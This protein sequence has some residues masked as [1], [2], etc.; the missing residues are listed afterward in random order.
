MGAGA[1]KSIALELTGT[2][3]GLGRMLDDSGNKVDAFVRKTKQS[4]QSLSAGAIAAKGL[5]IG[6]TAIA[7]GL[8]FAISK[9]VQFDKAM[10]NVN[11]LS[12]LN[13][14]QFAAM[15]K[16]VISMSTKLPQSA[17]VLAEGLYDIASSGFQGADGIKVLDAAAR[18]ASA[19]LTTTAV[20]ARAI[21]GV[22]NAYG[23]GAKD[24]AD[25]S[26]VLFSTVNL[27]VISFDELANNLGDVVGSAAAAKVSIAEVGAAIATMTLSGIKGAQATTSLSSLTTKLIQPSVALKDLYK[28]LGYESGAAALKA[29]GL[30]GVMED[31]RIATGGNITTMLKLFPDIE[32]ARGALA[33]MAVDGAN[34]A[35][36]SDQITDKNKRQGATQAVLNEQMKGVS[37]QWQLFTNKIDAAAISVGIKLLPAVTKTMQVTQDAGAAI[38]LVATQIGTQGAA[39]FEAL[40]HSAASIISLLKDLGTIA[41]SIIEPLAKVGGGALIG[42]FNALA[43]VLEKVTGFMADNQTLV[44]ALGAAYAVHAVGGISAM[45]SGMGIVSD[46]MRG[47]FT[48]S[49]YEAANGVLGLGD[50]AKA[51]GKQLL[52]MAPALAVGGAIAVAVTAWSSYSA[53]ADKAKGITKDVQAVM[54]SFSVDQIGA[55]LAK[56]KAF[57]ADYNSRLDDVGKHSGFADLA[58]D[59]GNFSKNWGTLAM[60]DNLAAVQDSADKASARI[61]QLQYNTVELL[62]VMGTPLPDAAKW[63]NDVQGANGAKAQADAMAQ[64][65]HVMDVLGPKLRAAGV[66]LGTAWDV[67]KLT[68]ASGAVSSLRDGSSQAAAAQQGLIDAMGGV[69]KSLGDAGTAAD[70]LKKALD[71]LMGASLG[72]DEATIAWG[73][74][75]AKLSKTLKENKGD[76]DLNSQGGRNNRKAIIDQVGAL[77]DVLV[78]SANAGEGQQA[79]T[80]K[81]TSGRDAL[82]KA[83]T[84]AG[85][86]KSEM[87]KL[88]AQYKLTPELVQ[89][90]IQQSGAQDTAAKLA[91]VKKQADALARSKPKPAVTL[92]DLASGRLAAVQNRLDAI[93]GRHATASVTLTENTYKNMIETTT[94]K[95]IGI[96]VNAN[97]GV[98]SSYANGKMPDQATI[99]PAQGKKGLVQW[100]EE[101]TGGEAYIPLAAS[102]RSRSEK[103]LDAVAG[104]FGK[105]V[106]EAN[107]NGSFRYPPFRYK[108][109]KDQPSRTEQWRTWS[110]ARYQAY[111]DYR[112]R[113]KLSDIAMGRSQAGRADVSRDPNTALGNVGTAAEAR[114]QALAQIQAN[115]SANP[116]DSAEDFYKKPTIAVSQ[117]TAALAQ[118]EKA[119]RQWGVDMRKVSSAV[120]NDVVESL[121]G[122][123]EQGEELIKKLARSSAKD[124]KAMADQIRKINFANF[125]NDTIQDVKGQ[126][127][128]QANLQAL[129]KMGRSDLAAHFQQMGY[130]SAA[131]LAAQAVKTPTA[132][133]AA[134]AS[135]VNQQDALNDPNAQKAYDLARILQGSGGRL[136]IIG[137]ANASGMSV[138]DVMGLLQTYGGSVFGKIPA[139]ARKQLLA[140][141]ALLKA[142][143]Q[144][145]GL[146]HGAIVRG[147]DTGYYWAEKS[148]G[149]ESLIPHGMD[150]RQRAL[151]LWQ[152]TGRILGA[153]QSH[154]GGGVTIQAGAITVPVHVNQTDASAADIETAVQRGTADMMNQLRR[155]LTSGSRG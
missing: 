119:Q 39:G 62:K 122:M 136:G 53:A 61:G 50:K 67:Q 123:G 7:A 104:V 120:G 109:G 86:N 140:D 44:L 63:I 113:V 124:M 130:D 47:K 23:L 110:D 96:R 51:A 95:D 4:N 30:H 41:L 25:V 17:T 29:K 115:R 117:Y 56:A 112:E 31:I 149:G 82:I 46:L 58:T 8:S 71:G 145:S 75:L 107:A 89:T 143:K 49:M 43:A 125:T 69:E 148:S 137:L 66:D 20:S 70:A 151:Q 83:G 93:D 135:V 45:T 155:M 77:Q 129:V 76:L 139:G 141:Q 103:I 87:V 88:L 38:A 34:Y 24:A 74:G 152:Q 26:D 116:G 22:L 101:E 28:Q 106:V 81:L 100:A 73:D 134:L 14:T 72:L 111:N 80:S 27:G 33:L 150:R 84:A 9:A 19:G 16:Q 131:G 21:T 147:S 11:S 105:I 2:N 108:P 126:Q 32:A 3:A 146:A 15:E 37:A 64:M 114:A 52:A 42:S 94:H 57:I 133:L 10:R 91:E 92:Q 59:I 55:E 54:N 118:S 6:V 128:F 90:L 60:G 97:G 85:I 68:E 99:M 142:G 132:S 98:W 144:P 154:G 78:A 13:E 65:S 138:G 102:K 127:Q 36:V 40:G 48:P 18:S 79:L 35:K 153:G 12:K 5:A 1:F 121:R